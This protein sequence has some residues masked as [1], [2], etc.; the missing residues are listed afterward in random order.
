MREP[1]YLPLYYASLT[2]KSLVDAYP[3]IV[4]SVEISFDKGNMGFDWFH[5]KDDISFKHFIFLPLD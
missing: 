5:Q 4:N 3:Q 2:D 1:T